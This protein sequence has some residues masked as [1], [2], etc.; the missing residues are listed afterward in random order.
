MALQTAKWM[1]GTATTIIVRRNR[2]NAFYLFKLLMFLFEI[3]H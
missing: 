1:G 3:V 2:I